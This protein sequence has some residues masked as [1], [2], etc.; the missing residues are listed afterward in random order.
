MNDPYKNFY[1]LGY[2]DA[3]SGKRNRRVPYNYKLSYVSGRYDAVS[4]KASRYE[5]HEE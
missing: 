4:G 5:Q 1:M 3:K 2:E